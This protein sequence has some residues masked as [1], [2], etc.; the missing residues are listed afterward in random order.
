MPGDIQVKIIA[1]EKGERA[2]ALS[3]EDQPMTIK[4]KS[5]TTTK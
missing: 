5:L 1:Y 4:N 3:A 2:K